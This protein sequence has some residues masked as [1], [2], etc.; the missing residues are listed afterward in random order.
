MKIFSI[1]VAVTIVAAAIFFSYQQFMT[2][3]EVVTNP[4]VV[5][6]VLTEAAS[7]PVAVSEP[8]VAASAAQ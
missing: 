3:D 2:P 8:A 7:A 4:I 6:P 5:G 1:I